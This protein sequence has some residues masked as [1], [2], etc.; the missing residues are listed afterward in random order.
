MNFETD[1]DDL[2]FEDID[3][4]PILTMEALLKTFKIKLENRKFEYKDN[5]YKIEFDWLDGVR[6]C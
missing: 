2:M 3:I 1:F 5:T 4:I 6:I